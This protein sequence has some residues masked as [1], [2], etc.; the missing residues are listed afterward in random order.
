MVVD[1]EFDHLMSTDWIW[2]LIRSVGTDDFNVS[3]STFIDVL[4]N[5]L[6]QHDVLED[7]RRLFK[8]FDLRSQGFITLPI[9]EQVAPAICAQVMPLMSKDVVFGLFQEADRDHDGRV[10]Y[11]DFEALVMVSLNLERTHEPNQEQDTKAPAPATMALQSPPAPVAS[12]NKNDEE[13]KAKLLQLLELP[14]NAL[15]ADCDTPAPRWASV[16]HGAFIC[17]QCAGV[18]RS[19][20]VHVSFV[21]SCT[22]D[23]WSEA[24]VD[25]MNAVGNDALNELLE[26]SVPEEFLKPTVDTPR[27]E[28]ERYI[29]AKYETLLFQ[30]SPDKIK[31]KAIS[32]SATST[33][34]TGSNGA[35]A[36]GMVEYVGVLMIDLIE[37][38]SLAG[39]DING[40]SDPYVVFRLGEQSITSKRVDN[41][42]N[43]KW[44]QKLMLSWDGTSP[45]VA[46][47][48]DYN[49][50]SADRFMGA[51]IIDGE[52]LQ[53]LVT[54]P[55]GQEMDSWQQV[56]MPRD[57]A[58]NFGEHML[59]GAEGV[60]RGFYRGITGVW[61]D[62]IK[63]AK[64][65][66]IEGFAKGAAVGVAGVFYRPIKGLGTMVKQ[67]ARGVGVG[68]KDAE[69]DLVAAGCLHM[70]VSLQ[71]F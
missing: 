47:V 67:T 51:V 17:T 25:H 30:L 7:A 3:E 19:L 42:L 14:G 45:L 20:G 66:G 38:I 70:K 43:P 2:I 27:N 13:V 44:N 64:K 57:W 6:A 26:F 40:K 29:R 21:L 8:A 62:P 5:R 53:T 49:K 46:E 48:Y 59:A 1:H 4:V 37:G 16:N 56:V 11:H 58:K 65:N 32:S 28:R 54:A 31:R 41:T 23:K 35:G 50:I 52:A 34:S 22:L 36:H 33:G 55:E 39:M 61:K 12:S 69:T 71:R 18:H 60:G 9:F 68:K 10:T 15:C 24:Q 63:G